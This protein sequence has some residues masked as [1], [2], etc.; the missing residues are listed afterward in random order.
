LVIHDWDI[1]SSL[2]P[3]PSL[4]DSSLPVLMDRIPQRPRPWIVP[5]LSS[6]PAALRYRFE[7]TG[8]EAGL[9]DVV[10]ENNEARLE[11]ADNAPA[12]ISLTCAT[13][14]FVLLMYGRL[15]LQSAKAV[16]R[17]VVAGDEGLIPDFDRWI[18]ST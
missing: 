14:T 9:W 4:P 18:K 16:G 5:F 6:L 3:S 13:D 12:N 1:R 15:T 2:E 7:L 11:R 10:V 17:L 8:A